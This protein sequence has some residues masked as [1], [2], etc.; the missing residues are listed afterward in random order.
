MGIDRLHMELDLR[1]Q[2]RHGDGAWGTFEP[3]EPHSP[4]ELDS[5]RQWP[6]G[7][8]YACTSCD[9]KVRVTP[10]EEERPPE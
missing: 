6:N 2:H 4:A 7:R 3:V 1:L 5:E 9:D 10:V 8:L